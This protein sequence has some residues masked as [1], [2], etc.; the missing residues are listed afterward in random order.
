MADLLT[1]LGFPARHPAP[2]WCPVCG[3]LE[4]TWHRSPVAPR[5]VPGGHDARTVT[6]RRQALDALARMTR[7]TQP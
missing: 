2:R 5:V 7:R 1:R 6:R 4:C 3:A